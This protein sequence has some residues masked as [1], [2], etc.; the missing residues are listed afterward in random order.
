MNIYSEKYS[1]K[2]SEEEIAQYLA[3]VALTNPE[4]LPTAMF[5]VVQYRMM[6]MLVDKF[7]HVYKDFTSWIDDYLRNNRKDR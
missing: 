4:Q 5:Q 6:M 2:Y 3:E 7:E 1:K